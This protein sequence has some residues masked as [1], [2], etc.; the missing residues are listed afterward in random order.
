MGRKK[1][2]KQL[3]VFLEKNR[4][5]VLTKQTTGAIEFR[6]T[7]EWIEKGFSISLSLP[8]EDKF[9]VGDQAAF[10]F[11][12]LLPDNKI[13][14]EA[15]AKKVNAESSRQFDLL[16]AIGRECVGALS[17]F[18]TDFT[19]VFAPKMSVRIIKD[20]EIADRIRGLATNNP[21][22]MDE[23]DFRLSLA[24]VQEKM[25]LL[26]HKGKWFE[27]RGQTA[28]SHILKKNMG[29]IAGG[30]NFDKSVDNEC[31]C[32]FLAKK[33]GI[34][35]CHA[36]IVTFED[37]RVLSVERFDRVW[38]E[39]FLYRI[40]QEDL[41]QSFGIPPN[42]KYERSGG[43]SIRN[44]MKLL[45]RSNNAEE[46]RKLFFKTVFFNDLIFNTD[47]HA[48]NFSIFLT[49]HGFALTPMY[50]L[51]SAHFMCGRHETRYKNLRS[52]LSV[53]GKF[54]YSQIGLRNWEKESQS[55]S[56]PSEVFDEI[57]QEFLIFGKNLN[58]YQMDLSNDVDKDEYRKIIE[59]TKN[60]IWH[61][62]HKNTEN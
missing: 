48:K 47:G 7:P 24:G 11:D 35:T 18:P 5:G 38:K 39:N 42:L 10:Y 49:R 44:M 25:A 2:T 16:A 28:T 30:I 31:I 46:D 62:F 26:Y 50:D 22:G 53:N 14:I 41:C 58:S 56:L 23:G 57:C 1:I 34:K 20:F 36:Q 6:Y 52:S 60:R 55:C 9:F 21:L 29:T 32:L 45:E 3:N 33:A 15:I 12:N 37:Q 27:P 61:V 4:I 59:G 13:I 51:L 19:P 43:P 8:L 17:F 54:H 40:P